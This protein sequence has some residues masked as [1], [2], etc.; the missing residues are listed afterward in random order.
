[1]QVAAAKSA[2]LLDA[3]AKSA[4]AAVALH[5]QRG[6]SRQAQSLE[7]VGRAALN[8]ATALTCSLERGCVL[9]GLEFFPLKI[10]PW[11]SVFEAL[12]WLPTMTRDRGMEG[13]V[14]CV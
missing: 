10:T 3:P 14:E 2:A 8:G 9:A 13:C 12:V 5:E 1:M 11:R 6:E 4:A 7:A